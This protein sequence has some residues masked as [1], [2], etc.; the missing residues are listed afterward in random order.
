M[1]ILGILRDLFAHEI[2]E[3]GEDNLF[4]PHGNPRLSPGEKG[5]L[6]PKE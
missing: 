4:A 1:F 6:V 5:F 2:W 3:D